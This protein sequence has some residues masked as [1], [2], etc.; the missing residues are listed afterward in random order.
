M[1]P[2][3]PSPNFHR[4]RRRPLA[5]VVWH[6][7]E[8]TERAGA[9]AA[10]ARNWFALRS[11]KVSAHVVADAAGV[12]ECVKPGDTAWHCAN[13]NADGYGVEVVGRAGQGDGWTDEYSL[14]AIRHACTWIRT[15]PALEGVPARWLTDDQL[16]RR[17]P[18]HTT[19]AQVAR[20]LGGTT[21]T[22]PG[23][24]FP[25]DYVMRQLGGRLVP[26]LAAQTSES[27]PAVRLDD[28][29][30]AVA[31]LQRW[32]NSHDWT[33]DLPLLVPD[34]IYGRRTAAVVRAAQAQCGVTGPDADGT[35]IGP[36]T[37]AAL[38]ARGWRA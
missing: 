18:G 35:V 1:A 25:L 29:G 33:P 6:S 31:S 2:W 24:A 22:D 13:G 3:I 32:L 28:R 20:V 19:H 34:G 26:G 30:P 17:Q 5:F 38:W 37:R 8:S 9:A 14:A 10:V 11:S 7:T 12:V 23:P 21:H 16:R 15:L 36:R 27:L 4:G